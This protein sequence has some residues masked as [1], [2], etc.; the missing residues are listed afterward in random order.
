MSNLPVTGI[1]WWRPTQWEIAKQISDDSEVFDDSYEI[2]K[3]AAEKK[4][5]ELKRHGMTVYKVDVDLDELSSWC[6][7]QNR[8]L[9]SSARSEFASH[10]VKEIH[11]ARMKGEGGG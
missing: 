1:I 7:S 3:A 5:R 11:E 8:P 2:W 9:D 6:K 10:K 4:I